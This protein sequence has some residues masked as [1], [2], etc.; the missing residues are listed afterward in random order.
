MSQWQLLNPFDGQLNWIE[1][2]VKMDDK[3]TSSLE[4]DML[5]D[6]INVE[7]SQSSSN[8]PNVHSMDTLDE[9]ISETLLRDLRGIAV[10]MRH[11]ILPTSSAAA[12]KSVLKDW[13]LWGPLLLC[14]FMGLALHHDSDGQVGPHFAEIVV[15]IW[16]GSYL[17]SL[18]YKLLSLAPQ[19]RRN[20]GQTGKSLLAS[21]SVFQLLCVLGY[22]LALPC[23]G[24]IVLKVIGLV[25]AINMKHLIYEKLLVST[26]LGFLWPTF[27]AVKI[28]SKYQ[29]KE[30]RPL[31]VYP[32]GL[33]FFVISW[34]LMLVH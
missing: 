22:C 9:P 12:Y 14:T 29:E 32:V 15:L 33:F 13:D 7:P 30:K 27:S 21:P 25:F 3:D 16:F 17:V 6:S 20:N 5:S 10:K 19:R 4:G 23:A 2:S 24:I 18:N 8:K 1:G 11:I 28:L 34:S 26:V 31:A